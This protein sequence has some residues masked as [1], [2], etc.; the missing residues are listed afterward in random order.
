M[1]TAA[2]PLYEDLPELGQLGTRH[3]WGHLPAEKGTLAFISSQ[4][5]LDAASLVTR[6][7]TVPLNLPV[8]AFDPPLFGRDQLR[9]EV[10]EASRN[11]AEDVIDRFNPQASSQLDGLGH[12]RAREFGYY[13]GLTA[14]D[15]ARTQLG[16]HHWATSGIAGRGILL[17]VAAYRADR[18]DD[19]DPFSGLGYTSDL[20]LET[21]DW[22]GVDLRA[23]DILLV[24]TGW[25][26]SYLSL[27][28][29]ER[30]TATGWDGLRADEQTAQFLWDRRIALVGSDNP[31]VENGP[32]HPDIGSLH[33]RL[34][35]S[36][37]MPLMEL[38][39]LE[40]LSLECRAQERWDFLFVSVPLNLHGAVSSPANAMA[41]L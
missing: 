33:R 17:D 8:N 37:G 21:A 12:V 10:V 13:G 15:E 28:A 18:G 26:K 30:P 2:V 11:D 16:M 6:G 19:T 14:L 20:L 23:G 1:T 27:S 25:A 35:P 9:H 40:T 38:L 22:A 39:D 32:G 24:R 34:L 3:S 5:I 41:L 31:A 4:Q 29:E 7:T 36:L